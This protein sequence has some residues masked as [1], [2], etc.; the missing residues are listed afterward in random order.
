LPHCVSKLSWKNFKPEGWERVWLYRRVFSLPREFS[1]RRVLLRF[2]GV[3]VKASPSIN[4]HALAP[5]LGGY[6][7]FSYDITDFLQPKD[8]VLDVEVDCRWQSVPPEGSPN[9]PSAIDYLE[10]GGIFRSVSLVAV[11]HV[12]LR[13]V[14]AKPV[15]VLKPSRHVVVTCSVDVGRAESGRFAI[16]VELRDGTRIV[17]ATQRDITLSTKAE[18]EFVLVL[19]TLGE[20]KLWDVDDPHLYDVVVFLM[21]GG[22]P[23][24]TLARRIGFREAEFTLDGFFLNGRRLQLFGLNRH[25]LFPYT[26]G[27]MPARAMRRDAEI[28]RKELNC[29]IV[30]CSHYPQ[31]EAFL[32]ACDELGM[33]VWE[34]TPGWQYIGDAAWKD[35]VVANVGDMVKRDRNH[36]SIVIWGV[37]VNESANDPGLYERTTKL[38]KSLDDSRPVSGSMVDFNGWQQGWHEDV[39]AIDDYHSAADG[40]VGIYAPL[41]KTL[42]MISETVGQFSYGGKGF[43]NVYQ[44]TAEVALQMQQAL[45]H[46]QAHD[47]AAA[48]PQI[49]GTIGWCAFDY[50][51]LLH[52]VDAMKHSGV[53]DF[54]RLPKLG[55][56][57]YHS[58]VD[59]AIRPVIAPNFYWDFGPATPRGP[60]KDAAVFSNCEELHIFVD[61]KPRTVLTPERNRFP[62]LQYPPFFMDMEMDGG[63]HPQ[64]RIEGY[65]AG[66]LVLSRSFSSDRSQDRLVL[67]ADDAE[68]LADGSDATRLVCSIVDK[69]GEP[70]LQRLGQIEFSAAGPG[71]IVGDNPFAIAE[72]GGTGAIW[73]K[74]LRGSG[75]KIVI[76]ATHGL[77]GSA[78][79][80]VVAK[81]SEKDS[82][83]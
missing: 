33:L 8:N 54:F 64:L 36:P 48:Y 24:H 55:A 12:Y 69:F 41:P 70:T 15:D 50:P 61:G 79:A 72:N 37:R 40:S 34:E 44:R 43:N 23:L 6:L 67:S 4:G 58:Q 29:N 35:Q 10:P 63:R 65:R 26:G 56:S 77:L 18:A 76:T 62:H 5:H 17:A 32:D 30:R 68:L 66:K 75:G 80:T 7:P 31:S 9:G 81:P 45:N 38:A 3:L 2:D 49:C 13:D 73:V 52:A 83:R 82:S 53:S 11:P 51:S 27:A 28:L 1:G 39:F 42:Y 60:G 20:V 74:T 19:D 25:E 14:F 57:F 59:P 47:K 21:A 46:A 78:T 16:K 71:N 22:Q